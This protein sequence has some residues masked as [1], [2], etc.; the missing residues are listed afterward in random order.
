M[1]SRSLPEKTAGYRVQLSRMLFAVRDLEGRS[2][3]LPV[4]SCSMF[5]SRSPAV[6]LVAG[7]LINVDRPG[8]S[9]GTL[10]MM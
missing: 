10:Y 7:L 3:T 6:G 8:S 2:M 9:I 4:G 5:G 1:L